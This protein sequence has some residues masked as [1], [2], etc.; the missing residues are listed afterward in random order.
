MELGFQGEEMRDAGAFAAKS[1]PQIKFKNWLNR[2]M[3]SRHFLMFLKTCT[4]HGIRD[5][6]LARILP[7]LLN[8][9]ANKMY[10]RLHID[11]YR[12]YDSV[13]TEILRSFRLSS[14]AYLQKFRMKKR[15]GDDSYSQFLH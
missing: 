11:T 13:K 15:Y 10:S 7:S 2:R 3:M 14:K 5:Q 9:K 6:Q 8:E 4:L 1:L 12:S